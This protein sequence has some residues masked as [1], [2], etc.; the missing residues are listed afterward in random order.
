MNACGK[1]NQ[2]DYDSQPEEDL[3]TTPEYMINRGTVNDELEDTF[4]LPPPFEA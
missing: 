3:D 2:E 1:I 4:T